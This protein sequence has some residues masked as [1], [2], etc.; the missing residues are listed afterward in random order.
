MRLSIN[1]DSHPWQWADL[2]RYI[3]NAVRERIEIENSCCFWGWGGWVTLSSERLIRKAWFLNI[4]G[5]VPLK[6][7]DQHLPKIAT[8]NQ[9]VMSMKYA[10]NTDHTPILRCGGCGGVGVGFGVGGGVG[11]AGGWA[12]SNYVCTQSSL[13]Q[14]STQFSQFLRYI[15]CQSHTKGLGYVS[16]RSQLV[17]S[18]RCVRPHR[19]LRP[20]HSI[21]FSS[22]WLP[23]FSDSTC[24]IWKTFPTD[25]QLNSQFLWCV[26]SI[27]ITKI[28]C[29]NLRQR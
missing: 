9:G 25:S 7:M 13:L 5:F 1:K 19:R 26:P 4:E 29:T 17:K 21:V 15:L 23:V 16:G 2:H 3:A 8:R 18:V 10:F 14:G 27:R 22:H 6:P 28:A 24:W 12:W 11:G 20:R